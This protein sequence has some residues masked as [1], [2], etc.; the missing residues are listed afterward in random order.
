MPTKNAESQMKAMNAVSAILLLALLIGV[1]GVLWKALST[2]D[3]MT[4]HNT[5][6][7]ELVHNATDKAGTLEAE[8][9]ELKIR[10]L[11]LEALGKA[12]QKR[13]ARAN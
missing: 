8:T 2:F 6:M 10:V 7:L 13:H 11:A 4:A 3:S 9:R 12:P 1:G 5:K